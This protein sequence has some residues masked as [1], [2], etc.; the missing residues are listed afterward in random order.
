MK[1]GD[2]FISILLLFL[3]VALVWKSGEL[4]YKVEFSPGP[5]FLPFWLGIILMILSGVLAV[6]TLLKSVPEKQVRFAKALLLLCGL[7]FS[8]LFIDYLGFI[9][10]VTLVAFGLMMI[11][12]W[13]RWRL[14]LPVAIGTALI[15]HF[16]FK[17][18]LEVSLPVGILK[19]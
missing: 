18:Y 8:N 2:L 19:F 13:R 9:I 5:G 14:N 12:D 10:T 15:L 16:F 17:K 3:G 6:T 11:L 1:R 4:T 7:G